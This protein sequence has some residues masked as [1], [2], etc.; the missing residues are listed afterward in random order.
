MKKEQYF[1]LI[2]YTDDG[3]DS[4][5]IHAGPFSFY[6]NAKSIAAASTDEHTNDFL[7]VKVQ[8]GYRSSIETINE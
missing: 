2:K 3:L 8:V 4:Y 6:D 1:V 7:V 5:D